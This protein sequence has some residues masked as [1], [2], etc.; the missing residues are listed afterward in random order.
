MPPT[1]ARATAVVGVLL[2]SVG[3]VVGLAG[4]SPDQPTPIA[5]ATAT[6]SRT[7]TPTPTPT[8]AMPTPAASPTLPA[9]W[10]DDGSAGAEAAARYFVDLYTYTESSQDVGPWIGI[11]NDECVF[12]QSV[13]DDVASQKAAGTITR[14]SPMTVTS[15]TTEELNPL[16]FSVV[17]TVAKEPETLW[18]VDGHLIRE[19]ED[20]GGTLTLVVLRDPDAWVLRAITPSDPVT[21]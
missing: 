5:S 14:S 21:K 19:G 2:V 8:I 3:I 9:E 1:A 10:T 6:V 11:S 17:L 20:V 12:C 7:P 15:A 16:A 4:C 13:L 18:S